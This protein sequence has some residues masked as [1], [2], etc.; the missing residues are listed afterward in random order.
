MLLPLSIHLGFLFNCLAL[1]F[2]AFRAVLTAGL[3]C[4]DSDFP[5]D[6]CCS[7]PPFEG[8]MRKEVGR[9]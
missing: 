6:G 5:L 4:P 8:C 2:S 1:L 9:A 3:G 7:E